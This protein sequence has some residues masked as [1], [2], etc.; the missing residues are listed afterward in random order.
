MKQA[1]GGAPRRA[2]QS[3]AWCGSRHSAR[4]RPSAARP[5]RAGA[6]GGGRCSAPPCSALSPLPHPAEG[7]PDL[8]DVFALA[9]PSGPRV[10]PLQSPRRRARASFAFLGGHFGWGGCGF[11]GSHCRWTEKGVR[12]K[13][14]FPPHASMHVTVYFPCV[15][16]N[17]LLLQ[18]T[19][20]QAAPDVL[21]GH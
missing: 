14:P 13:T 1:G 2:A 3:T 12:R 19:Y 20:L 17:V 18:A 10:L 11:P 5:R 16:I 21:G 7:E 4:L 9:V 8:A 6:A 15:L